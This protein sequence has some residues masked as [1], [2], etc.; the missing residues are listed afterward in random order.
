[1]RGRGENLPKPL[2]RYGLGEL[3]KVVHPLLGVAHVD[4]DLER[5]L[6]VSSG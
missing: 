3:A 5:G 6:S 4:G 2:V 1:M